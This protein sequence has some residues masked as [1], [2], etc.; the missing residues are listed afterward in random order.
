MRTAVVA[1]L[2]T[3]SAAVPVFAQAPAAPPSPATH[4]LTLQEA[5]AI[6]LERQPNILAVLSD[7]AAARY[8][9]DIALAPLMPQLTGGVTTTKSSQAVLPQSLT[10]TAPITISRDF[11]QTFLGQ[12]SVSQLLFDFGQNKA[13]TDVA[14]KNAA[15]TLENVELQRQL[16]T[17]TVKQAFTQLNFAKRLMQVNQQALE[18]AEL[19]LR[20]AKGFF[21]VGTQPKS[22]VTRAE[23]DVANAGVAIIQARNAERVARV[24]LNVAMGFAADTPTEVTDNLVYTPVQFDAPQLHAE[25]IGRAHV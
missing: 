8:Q 24:A 18:R 15:V 20:S 25:E 16:I 3:V 23:V 17:L 11:N 4:P 5:V 9:V 6:A 22:A 14:R 21:E 13:A 19:N 12:V 1:L 10:A 7:Y 2:L